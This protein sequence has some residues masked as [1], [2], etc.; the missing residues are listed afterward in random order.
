MTFV[1]TSIIDTKM[2]TNCCKTKKSNSLNQALKTG[3]II[4]EEK[5]GYVSVKNVNIFGCIK[6]YFWLRNVIPYAKKN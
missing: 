3:A 6:K 4:Q 2:Y 5:Y 1:F